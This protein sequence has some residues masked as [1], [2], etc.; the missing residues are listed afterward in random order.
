MSPPNPLHLPE[1]TAVRSLSCQPTGCIWHGVKSFEW[2]CW[3]SL[4]MMTARGCCLL[5]RP[6]LQIPTLH[7]LSHTH[8]L[9]GKKS[10]S[11]SCLTTHRP[12]PRKPDVML[13]KSFGF[14]SHMHLGKS[15]ENA[16]VKGRQ[17]L[18]VGVFLLLRGAILA[19]YQHPMASC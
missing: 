7:M 13:H 14:S 19:L 15:P 3:S 1:Y 9:H 12:E 5:F 8:T 17:N 6:N 16:V 11:T 18:E 4:E 2:L 10:R